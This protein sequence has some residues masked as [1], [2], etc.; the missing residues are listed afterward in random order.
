MPQTARQMTEESSQKRQKE[1]IAP[2]NQVR[3]EGF[4]LFEFEHYHFE[5]KTS[6]AYI[7]PVTL[8]RYKTNFMKQTELMFIL[9]QKATL[10]E[11]P[12]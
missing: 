11:S 10:M 1:C 2:I 12:N 9:W 4:L 8:T 6:V 7:L 3:R 5:N